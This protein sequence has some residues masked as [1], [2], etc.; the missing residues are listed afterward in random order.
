MIGWTKLEKQVV[1]E[2][3]KLRRAEKRRT[4]F[5]TR[6]SYDHTARLI[7]VEIQR[8]PPRDSWDFLYRK[9]VPWKVVRFSK[10]SLLKK[11]ETMFTDTTW[12]ITAQDLTRE[13]ERLIFKEQLL[14]EALKE[15]S[16]N[17]TSQICEHRYALEGLTTL[18]ENT[19]ATKKQTLTKASEIH[20]SISG[21]A[22]WQSKV[23]LFENTLLVFCLREE[24]RVYADLVRRCNV[25]TDKNGEELRGMEGTIREQTNSR[26]YLDKH[27][28]P[29]LLVMN[30]NYKEYQLVEHSLSPK[31]GVPFTYM[32]DYLNVIIDQTN[33]YLAEIW[34]SEIEILPLSHDK[35]LTFEF[36]WTDM[37]QIRPDIKKA[38]SGQKGIMDV[39]MNLALLEPLCDEEKFPVFLDEIGKDFDPIHQQNF[40]RF[41]MTLVDRGIAS[42]IFLISHFAN[43]YRDLPNSVIMSLSSVDND[44]ENLNTHLEVI[45]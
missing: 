34:T 33:S 2:R 37:G 28:K 44:I 22:E 8:L 17:L 14:S 15:K 36:P 4:A 9:E 7:F 3:V 10:S 35:A 6:L 20:H 25:V 40:I 39:L 16:T 30:T 27:I 43:M 38:S 31:T 24:I 13:I 23:D 26:E 32:V 45:T 19:V 21:E 42:Q 18:I 41:V 29:D 1:I 12:N 11:F 5:K